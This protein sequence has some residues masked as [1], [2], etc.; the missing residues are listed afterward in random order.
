V[1]GTYQGL[2]SLARVVGPF[3]GEL[4]LGAWGVAAP[5]L[6][7]AVFTTAA[8]LTAAVTIRHT[9]VRRTS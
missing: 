6:A 8:A 5:A 2:S 1:L 7:A 3:G 9:A 4:A